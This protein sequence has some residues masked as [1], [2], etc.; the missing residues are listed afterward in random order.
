MVNSLMRLLPLPLIAFAL[1]NCANMGGAP[2]VGDVQSIAVKACAFLPTAET[3]AKIISS[4]SPALNTSAAIASAICAA[5]A[6]K[7]ASGASKAT[8]AGVPVEG[9]KVNN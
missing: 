8:V 4:N 9:L 1:T 6:P 3:V 5:V 2:S 7:S